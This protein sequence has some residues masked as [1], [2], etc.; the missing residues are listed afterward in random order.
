MASDDLRLKVMV[1]GDSISHGREGDWTWRYRI[2]EWFRQEKISAAFVG[3]YK[4][5]VPPDPPS[6]PRPPPLASEPA[7]PGFLRTDGGYAN[8]VSEDFLA[9]SR[10]FAVGGRQAAQAK[11]LVAEQVA[12]YEPDLLLVQLGFNDISWGGSRPEQ[13]LASMKTLVDEARSARPDVKFAVANVPQRTYIPG[14][15]D[16]PTRTDAYNASLAR[17]IPTWSTAGSP[18]ALVHFRENYSCGGHTSDAA[19]DGLHPNALGEY[20]LAQAFSRTLVD[21]FP[22]H[23]GGRVELSIPAEIPARPTPTPDNVKAEAIPGGIAVTWDSVYGAFGYDIRTR[24]A[25]GFPIPWN[26]S[27]AGCNRYDTRWCLA[28]QKWEYQVRTSGGDAVKSRW[29]GVV[30]AVA[31]PQ[32]APGPRN[33]VTHATAT[34]YAI[35]WDPPLDEGH[36]YEVDRYGVLTHDRDI[37]GAFPCAVGVRETEATIGGLIPGHHH[38]I[39]VETWTAAGGGVPAAARSVTVG[40]GT[41]PKPADVRAVAISGNDNAV[42]L[43][44]TGHASA[45]GYRC[46]ARNVDHPEDHHEWA[47]EEISESENNNSPDNEICSPSSTIRRRLT[48][49]VPSVWEY[50]FA[51]T[52]YNGNDESEKSEWV[53]ARRELSPSKGDVGPGLDEGDT[54]RIR[55]QYAPGL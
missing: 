8:G 42:E 15:D 3:P 4:G 54:L 26:T 52:A 10:H 22:E 39:A 48:D 20:Q 9:N 50:E 32:T 45:A 55:L 43:S 2:W 47:S 30:S 14:F 53:V 33:V 34:G 1:V 24:L 12:T 40:A 51:V 23:F 46:F 6:P 44:W 41:P 21:A 31:H 19:Y 5:T 28:G 13:L 7:A 11:D 16:L 38:N 29:S 27:S 17:A 18:I 36:D 37:P 25:I 35:R 49:L